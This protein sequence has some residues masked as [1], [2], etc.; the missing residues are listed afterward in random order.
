MSKEDNIYQKLGEDIGQVVKTAVKE[1]FRMQGRS[2]T[3]ALIN[4]ID[5]NVTAT[6]NSAFIEF[7][8]LDYGM[9]L[10]Y[11]V[12]PERIPYSRGSGAKGSKY[13]DGLKAYA[14][15]KFNVNDKTAL[16]IA[17]AIAN[18]HKKF[19]MPLDRKTGAVT[20][21]IENSRQ[22]VVDLIN[23]ALSKLITV[24]FVGAFVDVKKKGSD[25]LKIKYLDI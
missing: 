9:I 17:F 3:G 24:M 19:G 4:S 16:Q 20:D 23:N 21:G 12:P 2:L 13:I 10:N 22:E 11:G 8:L 14:K 18:K 7:T 5:Y 6:I 1:S 25:S 15:L